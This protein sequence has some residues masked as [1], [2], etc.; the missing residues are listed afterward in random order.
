LPGP[1]ASAAGESLEPAP[2]DPD[3]PALSDLRAAQIR[4]EP[5]D[6]HGRVVLEGGGPL[7][8]DVWLPA[9]AL[10]PSPGSTVPHTGSDLDVGGGPLPE[11][12]WL[13]ARA[14][15]PSPGST[16][17]TRGPDVD[18]ADVP[19][20]CYMPWPR[21]RPGPEG[22]FT[23]QQVP[24]SGAWLHVGHDLLFSVEPVRLQ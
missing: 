3:A 1:D 6:V 20:V 10:P 8:D 24:V 17:P 11:Y 23:L 7:P 22:T 21:T 2:A 4:E 12:V 14:L 16:G 13:S 19:G 15:P 5:F 9:S 18:G